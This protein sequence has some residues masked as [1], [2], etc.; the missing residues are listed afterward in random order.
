M[1]AKQ[2]IVMKVECPRCKTMQ[3]IHVHARNG[4][5]KGNDR[6][7]CIQCDNHFEVAVA[8]KIVGGP[9]PA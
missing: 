5:T 3:K 2:Y 7:P 4:N 8:D 6:I 1:K 9:F